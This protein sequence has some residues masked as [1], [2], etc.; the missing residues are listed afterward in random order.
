MQAIAKA[1]FVRTSPRKARLVID[2]IRGKDVKEALAILKFTPNYAARLIEKVVQS[3]AANAENNFHMDGDNLK[4]AVAMVDG[5][6]NVLKR[7]RHAPMG[8]GY[9]IVK[10]MSHITIALE[11]TEPKVAKGK[12]REVARTAKAPRRGGPAA[13]SPAAVEQAEP[14]ERK[15][16]GAAQEKAEPRK[17]AP[18]KAEREAVAQ[19]EAAAAPEAVVK[20][21]PTGEVVDL[22][23][24]TAEGTTEMQA[25]PAEV[26]KRAPRKAKPEVL[27]EPEAVAQPEAAAAPEAVVETVPTGEIVDLKTAAAE[28]TTEMQAP[29]AEVKKRAPRKAKPEVVAEAAAEQAPETPESAA[30]DEKSEH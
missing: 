9:R 26:K 28:G 2:A 3:A 17:R 8:R 22:K 11:E 15:A 13:P 18:R 10:R 23:T 21:V 29:R 1:R 5:G 25:P 6:P 27:A 20:T 19:P 4:V 7:V 14:K 12:R 24:A 30:E 16:R